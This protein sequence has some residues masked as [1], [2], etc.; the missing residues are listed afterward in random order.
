MIK[1]PH[2]PDIYDRVILER[3]ENWRDLIDIIP[4][5]PFDPGW[6]VQVIPP[7]GGAICRFYVW[8]GDKIVSVYLDFYERLGF[9]DGK[10]Y[11]EVYR[12]GGD[13][14]RCGLDE[15]DKLLELIHLGFKESE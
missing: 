10:P 15:V 1:N 12:V 5:I 7:F 4:A 8:Q 2:I 6:K 13:T 14:S 11:W 9:Y 3:D